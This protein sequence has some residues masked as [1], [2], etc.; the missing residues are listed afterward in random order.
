MAKYYLFSGIDKKRGFTK[1]QAAYL[2][3]DLHNN[4]TITFI[5]SS[6][7][8]FNVNDDYYNNMLNFF[9][10]IEV[11]I[12]TSYLIDDRI[13]SKDAVRYIKESDAIFI[14][15]GYPSEEM[16]NISKYKLVPILKKFPGIIMGVSAGSIN[17]NK[18]ICYIDKNQSIVK[19]KGIGLVDFN[20]APHLDFNNDKYLQEIYTVSKKV[21]TLGLPNDSF[22]IV[23]DD[24][25]EIIGEYYFFEKGQI[26]N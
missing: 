12:K 13:S 16:K 11:K 6:F 19:Y 23:N 1:N 14:M 8:N 15:G 18:N 3:K 20:I 17:M 26:E 25:I 2:K 22:I 4:L 9:N 21:K 24:N 5:A 10:K 7:D